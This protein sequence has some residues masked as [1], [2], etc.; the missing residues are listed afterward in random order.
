[1]IILG[2]LLMF[3]GGGS[4]LDYVLTDGE[5]IGQLFGIPISVGMF[6]GGTVLFGSGRIVEVLSFTSD[7]PYEDGTFEKI[8]DYWDNG[9][10]NLKGTKKNGKLDGPYE[11]YYED[12][13]LRF[14]GTYKDG[15]KCGEWVEE[16]ETV[17]HDPC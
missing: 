11:W 1:M 12:G 3:L 10:L 6:I 5:F 16:G 15:Q 7:G 14:K 9:Q 8:E 4:I 2:L 17:T 13:Q